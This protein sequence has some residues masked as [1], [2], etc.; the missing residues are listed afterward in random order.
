ML[1]IRYLQSADAFAYRDL[2]LVSY[3]EAPYAFSESFED[4]NFG[5]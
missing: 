2:R 4:E 5:H 1:I 3:Q